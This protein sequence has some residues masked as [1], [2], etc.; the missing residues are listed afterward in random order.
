MSNAV[1]KIPQ[2]TAEGLAQNSIE[3]FVN[4]TISEYYT[5][6][7][8]PVTG[9]YTDGTI[10]DTDADNTFLLSFDPLSNTWPILR[11]RKMFPKP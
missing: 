1:R 9:T 8:T 2:A 4:P 10:S 5:Y 7:T 11:H 3:A 6:Q